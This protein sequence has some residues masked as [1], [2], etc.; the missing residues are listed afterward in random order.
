[1]NDTTKKAPAANP[2]HSW[3]F[4]RAGGVDQVLIRSGA[5]IENLGNLDLKLWFALSMPTSGIEFD[6]ATL[7]MIDTDNDGHIRPPE[8]IAAVR[9]AKG[10]F[11]SLND[12]AKGGDTVALAA[13]G[14]E[15]IRK[16][17]QH[18]LDT[19]GKP[20]ATAISLADVCQMEKVFAQTRF[21]GDGIV[22][23][24]SADDEETRQAIA[25]IISALGG[26][27]DRS[28]ATGVDAATLDACSRRR[29]ITAS[30]AADR[31][32]IRRFC[33]AARPRRMRRRQSQPFRS[34]WTTTSCACA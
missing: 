16:S 21:N 4:F 25:D 13:I 7:A 24:Q 5:D 12:L 31:Q 22:P 3:R 11:V 29:R 1:M 14:D 33:P 34:R 8:I 6:R 2:G 10:A 30:G 23:P 20:D 32:P 28:G 9:W 18:I 19:L 15:V 17:A 27:L 26:P